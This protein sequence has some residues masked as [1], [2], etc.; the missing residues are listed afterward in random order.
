MTS[1][2]IKTTLHLTPDSIEAFMAALRPFNLS[3]YICTLSVC[4]QW[5]V[6]F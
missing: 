3:K 4:R 2:D 5:P 6:L 1:Y